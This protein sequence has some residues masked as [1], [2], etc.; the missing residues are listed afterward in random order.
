MQNFDRRAFL[1]VGSLGLFGTL[2]YG[3]VLRL[4]A[5]APSTA[6]RDISIIHLLLSGGIAQMDS[7][8]PKPQAESAYRSLFQPIDT[9]VPGM[10]IIEH[11]PLT[12]QHANK[13]SLIRSMRHKLISHESAMALVCS[14]NEPLGTVQ[15]PAMQTVIAKEL[16]PA[17]RSAPRGID[18]VGHRQLGKMRFLEHQVQ[19][20]QRGRPERWQLQGP[21]SR[22]ADG[23]RLVAHGPPALALVARR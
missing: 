19:P 16:G 9:A 4:R 20:V 13:F 5:A 10:R 15:F 7:W 11:L 21:R 6:E 17:Q 12:A 14:G 1:K 3:D 22:L 8:D 23:S 18:P 2:A